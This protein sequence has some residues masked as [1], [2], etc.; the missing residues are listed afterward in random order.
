MTGS[1]LLMSFIP[2]HPEIPG[3]GLSQS[4]E[5]ELER[6]AERYSELHG[7]DE[8]DDVEQRA[9]FLARVVRRLRHR[10]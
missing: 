10:Q 9:G 6:K 5:D 7:S 1:F 3:E 8:E 4:T 2:P